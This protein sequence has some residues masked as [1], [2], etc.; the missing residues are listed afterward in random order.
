MA[1]TSTVSS[2]LRVPKRDT[3]GY[4]TGKMC[5]LS[6]GCESGNCLVLVHS[7]E[8]NS[9]ITQLNYMFSIFSLLFKKLSETLAFV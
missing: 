5:F 8:Y 7:N 9:K 4:D 2:A 1:I 3:K 6:M